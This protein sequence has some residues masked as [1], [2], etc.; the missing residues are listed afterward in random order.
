MEKDSTTS[1]TL[2]AVYGSDLIPILLESLT[3]TFDGPE[4]FVSPEI[5]SV[6]EPPCDDI[7]DLLLRA[8]DNNHRARSP[9]FTA[10]RRKIRTSKDITTA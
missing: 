9:R 4:T 1:N 7:R 6:S 8:S 2:A 10:I 3:V 5:A